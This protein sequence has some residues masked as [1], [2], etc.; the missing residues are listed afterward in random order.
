M[1]RAGAIRLASNEVVLSLGAALQSIAGFGSLYGAFPEMK[2]A[3]F[4]AFSYPDAIS[5]PD[6]QSCQ[7]CRPTLQ[8]QAGHPYAQ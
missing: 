8:R 7:A 6:L 3:P 1:W 5:V 4:G 2:K